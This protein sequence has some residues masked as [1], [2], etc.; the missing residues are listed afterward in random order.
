MTD[1]GRLNKALWTNITRL[2][3][4]NNDHAPVRFQLE[5]SPFDES[6]DQEQKA[7]A[8]KDEYVI[9]G[10]IFPESNIYKESAFRIEMIL[11]PNY[12]VEPPRV[13]FLTPVY[14]PNIEKDGKTRERR[15]S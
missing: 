13:R 15:N 2:K 5:N 14:H 9:V 6:E 1:A 3:L 10:R 4:L 7:S 12:P 8:T 11:T